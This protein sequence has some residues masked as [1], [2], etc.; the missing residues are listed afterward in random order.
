MAEECMSDCLGRTKDVSLPQSLQT[1]A[2]LTTHFCLVKAWSYSSPRHTS[3]RRSVCLST[4]EMLLTYEAEVRLWQ[5]TDKNSINNNMLR[6]KLIKPYFPTANDWTVLQSW[7]CWC[8]L[9]VANSTPNLL[10]RNN[11]TLELFLPSICNVGHYSFF[12]FLYC[13]LHVS[14][15]LTGHLQV[16]RLLWSRIL[17]LTVIRLSFLLVILVMWVT[18]SFIWVSLGCKWLFWL[19]LPWIF[20]L[21]REFCCMLAGHHSR[22][23]SSYAL[24]DSHT[25]L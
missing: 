21:G 23:L 1:V 11:L 25:I 6:A 4:G 24:S 3:S 10:H 15:G 22:S 14:A 9:S 2:G 12:V 13:T 19:L 20:V 7:Y 5:T 8:R 16:Y 17:L 18:I